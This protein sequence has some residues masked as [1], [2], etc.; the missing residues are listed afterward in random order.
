MLP[1]VLGS[2]LGD[3][4]KERRENT[5]KTYGPIS[6]KLTVL[7]CTVLYCTVPYRAVVSS[8]FVFLSS[9][10]VSA[11][12][13]V[14]VKR[15]EALDILSKEGMLLVLCS[16]I[17]NMPYVVAEAAVRPCILHICNLMSMPGVVSV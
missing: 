9:L 2:D 4:Y 12:W 7:Y 17:D 6:H 8:Q 5:F 10:S 1:S 13:Q 15:D 3:S 11:G 16:L 14:N